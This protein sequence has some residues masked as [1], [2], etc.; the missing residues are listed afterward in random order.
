MTGLLV[1][2]DQAHAEA[3]PVVGLGDLAGMVLVAALAAL[4]LTPLFLR[5][6]RKSR[7]RRR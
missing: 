5:D 1:A 7:R 4:A 6:L 3:G 2:I